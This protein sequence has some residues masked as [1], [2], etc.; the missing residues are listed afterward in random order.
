MAKRYPFT[1]PAEIVIAAWAERSAGPGWSNSLVWFLYRDRDG[2]Y[3]VECFQPS[4]QTKAMETLFGVCAEASESMI[5]AVK[6]AL[7]EGECLEETK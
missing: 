4:E 6:S 7:R 3:K 2:T 5:M 1:I